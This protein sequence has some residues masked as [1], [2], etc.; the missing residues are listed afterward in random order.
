VKYRLTISTIILSTLAL[1]ACEQEREAMPPAVPVRTEAAKR[2]SF[3][4]SLTLLGVVRAAQSIPLAA[5]QRGAIRY[6]QRFA[7][8]LQ[9]G[10]RVSRGELIAA[11]ENLD[12]KAAQTEA[13]LEMEAAAADFERAQRSYKV[14]VISQ[15]EHEEKHV[16]ATLAKERFNAA[17]TR[18]STL[19]VIAPA[20]GTLVVTKLYPA[21]SVVDASA[22]LAEIATA[23][24][25]LVE[26]S[27]AASERPLLRPGLPVTFTARG[28]PAWNGSGR[29]EE[30]AAV[31]GESGTSRVVASLAQNGTLP[32]PG[33]GVEVTVRMEPRGSVLTVPEDAVVAGTEGPAL[34]VA[35]TSEG[36]FNRFRVKRVPVVTG[37]RANG[38]IE[39]TSGLHDGDRVVI[40]GVDAMTDDAI[41]AEVSDKG[42]R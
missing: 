10:A 25:P 28:T 39:I 8:G 16:R 31:V 37:G 5:Q 36:S 32:P 19:R 27:V 30:V 26:S 15:A 2:A 42:S 18:L 38:R 29:I 34:F 1:T 14:G 20:S 35:A 13:R 41:A 23:G 21:G 33:T 9:T 17:S 12:V 7:N 11:V 40:S 22:T 4:P 6:P 3:T 24:A